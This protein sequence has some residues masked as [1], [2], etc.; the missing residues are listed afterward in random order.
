MKIVSSAVWVVLIL[1]IV[2]C[3]GPAVL[4]AEPRAGHEAEDAKRLDDLK[5]STKQEV[6]KARKA[7]PADM[8]YETVF[9]TMRD[10]TKLPAEVFT[11]PGKGPWPVYLLKSHYG[12][13]RVIGYAA[14]HHN[15]T[16]KLG[17][18][19]F[20][21]MGTRRDKDALPAAKIE[22]DDNPWEGNDCYD[23]VEWCAAQK[24]SNGRV[25][26]AGGSG[27]GICPYNAAVVAPPHLVYSG[28]GSSGADLRHD[29][30]F[31]NGVRRGMYDWLGTRTKFPVPT[32]RPYNAAGR[33]A[34]LK[35]MAA[36][37]GGVPFSTNTGWYDLSIEAALDYFEAFG[38]KGNVMVRVGNGHHAGPISFDGKK[39]RAKNNL[40][41]DWSAEFP[42]LFFEGKKIVK[43]SR[44][45]YYVLGDL[46]DPQAPGNVIK[47]TPIWPVPHTPTPL[48]L[49]ADGS[50]GFK[51]PQV[52]ATAL[53]YI[54]DPQKPIKTI[55]GN[56]YAGHEGGIGGPLD[57]RPLKDRTDIL[58]FVTAPLT[59]PFEIVGKLKA[60]IYL[61]TDVPDTTVAVKIVD[62]Y[63]DGYEAIMRDSIV[64]ARYHGGYDKPSPLKKGTVYKLEMD[65]WSIAA[66]FNKGHRI[67]VHISGSNTPKY[68]VHPNS[69]EPVRTYDNAPIAHNRLH[70]SK[71]HPSQIIFP[72]PLP[73][74]VAD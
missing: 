58:R 41:A 47:E 14:S 21:A 16:Q 29:W 49:H 6:A 36:K 67:G 22:R 12:R 44:L 52:A 56:I 24:W 38:P 7:V 57:Q 30:T 53:E 23:A 50:A 20:V 68:E 19:V 74:P 69:Y 32:I 3:G 71:T 34:F 13:F 10:G 26:M 63:P 28:P 8:T 42:A 62:I 66:I 4:G 54:Y 60:D 33:R 31:H 45:T 39:V 27:N 73:T 17:R 61:E 48:Y 43:K 46:K 65:M 55:G 2:A 25:F 37:G 9:V 51:A 18:T 35:E 59:E 11:P 1:S 64:M 5:L 40:R 70:M 15:R 72:V